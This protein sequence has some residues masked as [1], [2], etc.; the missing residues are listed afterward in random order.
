MG[1]PD[2]I[3]CRAVLLSVASGLLVGS[4]PM[5]A[6]TQLLNLP[7]PE[8]VTSGSGSLAIDQG[9]QISFEG[10]VEPRLERARDRFL[11]QLSHETGIA[12]WPEATATQPRFV[13]QTGHA[14]EPVRRQREQEG[15]AIHADVPS[16]AHG[17]VGWCH[18]KQANVRRAEEFQV[19]HQGW[20]EST[21]AIGTPGE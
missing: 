11:M 6:Q 14:S 13:I 3:C 21:I 16:H 4:I 1:R 9:L 17:F 7:L 19:T 8:H 2:M 20:V 18:E 12:Q 15:L 10:F 5:G